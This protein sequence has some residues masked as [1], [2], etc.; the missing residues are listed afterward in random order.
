MVLV[1]K[2]KLRQ[3]LSL[4]MVVIQYALYAIMETHFFLKKI[5][6]TLAH[7]VDYNVCKI[8]FISFTHHENNAFDTIPFRKI[9]KKQIY[10]H[11]S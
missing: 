10:L 5:Y 6:M 9:D 4:K 7:T 3:P 11:Y 8:Y 1:G 2:C